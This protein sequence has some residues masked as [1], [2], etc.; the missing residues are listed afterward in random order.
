M[1]PSR[2]NFNNPKENSTDLVGYG[3][4]EVI[5]QNKVLERMAESFF[6]QISLN[7]SFVN[8]QARPN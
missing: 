5:K 3:Q 7:K 6:Q 8:Y 1:E 4:L 2:N